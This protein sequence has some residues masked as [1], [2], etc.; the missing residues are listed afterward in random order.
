M[1]AKS[2]GDLLRS[3]ADEG[4]REVER[5]ETMQLPPDMSYPFGGKEG[6]IK[7]LKETG[8]YFGKEEE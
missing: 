2:L 8:R 4:D 6:Y 7:W 5:A 3:L 1:S